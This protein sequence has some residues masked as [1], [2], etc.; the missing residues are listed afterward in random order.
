MADSAV[1][2]LGRYALHGEI[3]AGGMATVH[4]GRLVGPVGFSRTVAIKRLHA[5][6]AK[7]PDFVAMFLDEA[8]LAARIQHPNVVQTLDV[9]STGGEVF[10]VMEYV[11]GE[12]LA[13]LIRA[14]RARGALLPP[15]VVGA[16]ATGMLYGL[17]AAH[18]AKSERGEHLEIIHRDVSPQ[19]ILVGLDGVSRVLDFGVA[20]AVGRAQ[21]TKDGKLKGKLAYMPPEQIM[22]EPL[23]R[24][25]DV[26]A[27]A[28][29]VWEALVGQRLFDGENEGVILKKIL[30]GEVPP[31]SRICPE[32]GSA[33]DAVVLKA[34]SRKRSSRFATAWD[35]AVA[36]EETLGVDAPRQVGGFVKACAGEAIARRALRVQQIETMTTEADLAPQSSLEEGIALAPADRSAPTEL[37]R[38]R[39]STRALLAVLAILG[40]G[41]LAALTIVVVKKSKTAEAS[42]PAAAASVETP[43]SSR[44]AA[45]AAVETS[46]PETPTSSATARASEIPAAPTSPSASAKVEVRAS[47]L[48]TGAVPQPRGSSIVKPPPG[49]GPSASDACKQPTYYENGIKKIKPQCLK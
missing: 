45:T 36:L 17:H 29:V 34:L 44:V 28:V 38:D 49:E 19:N 7:D 31:P 22:G 15:R 37:S 1:Q 39:K 24:R 33:L 14:M 5:Q 47:S 20:K 30:D 16:I 42:A 18:E 10:L 8:R 11:E 21:T 41:A 26:Y 25:V 23:D 13:R 6:Y 40:A 46:A 43:P 48:R 35:F 12:S 2:L 3:A 32:L 27:A 4:L 9:V